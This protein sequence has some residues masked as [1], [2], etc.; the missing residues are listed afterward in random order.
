MLGLAADAPPVQDAQGKTGEAPAKKPEEKAEGEKKDE[1]KKEEEKKEEEFKVERFNAYGQATVIT[2]WNGPFRSPYE[3]PHSFL[4]Q[5]ETAT[6]VTST[7]FL[8][9]RFWQGCEVYFNPEIAGGRG[10]SDVFGIAA[11]PNGD[12]TRVGSPEPTPYVARLWIQ[13]TFGFGGEQEKIESGPNQLAEYKDISRLTVAAGKMA[14]TDWFD[15]NRYS[16]DPRTQF[17]NW[18]LMYNGA[19]DYPADVRGYNYG[20][21]V[22]LNQK[23]WA[24][25]YGVF[26]EPEV[27]NGAEIDPKI[28]VAHGQAV[29]LENRYKL[30]DRPG[31]IR[32]LA[33]WNRAHMGNYDEALALSPSIPT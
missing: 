20:V 17:M 10:L 16:H 25:R 8:G 33:Y 13:Q 5:Q 24:L 15:Q 22:E 4:S 30:C 19:W 27:A 26:G 11:F 28:G 7:L 12:I 2:Q 18:G 31:K 23:D 3:G 1:E 14:A 9:A 21:V 32:W 29:E 6:S